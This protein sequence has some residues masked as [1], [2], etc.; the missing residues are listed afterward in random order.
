MA[1]HRRCFGLRSSIVSTLDQE[2][3]SVPSRQ[4]LHLLRYNPKTQLVQPEVVC[5]GAF[6]TIFFITPRQ[7]AVYAKFG[8]TLCVAV[9]VW[10]KLTI[11]SFAKSSVP[12]RYDLP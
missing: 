9:P 8:A 2:I 7:C 10:H 3:P 12:I 5:G 4:A 6:R 11:V 1:V